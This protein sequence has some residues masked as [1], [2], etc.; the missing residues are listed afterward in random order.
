MIQ[1]DVQKSRINVFCQRFIGRGLGFLQ[2]IQIDVGCDEGG[3]NITIRW[4]EA[5]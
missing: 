3:I 4:A 5:V 2:A 1:N